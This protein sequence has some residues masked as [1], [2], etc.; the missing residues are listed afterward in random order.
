MKRNLNLLPLPP[1]KDSSGSDYPISELKLISKN[2][3]PEIW[4]SYL[5]SLEGAQTEVLLETAPSQQAVLNNHADFKF[6][7]YLFQAQEDG[8]QV[9][10]AELKALL[11][12]SL[13]RRERE[14]FWMRHWNDMTTH[15]ISDE[16]KISRRTVREIL[17]RAYEKVRHEIFFNKFLKS[18]FYK[19]L[20]Q[21]AV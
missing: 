12:A 4:E 6:E 15:A 5:E 3:T 19:Y 7:S 13:S 11:R 21:S 8:R 17:R 16:L 18:N 20:N 1:W 2:W 10:E 9:F 14:I